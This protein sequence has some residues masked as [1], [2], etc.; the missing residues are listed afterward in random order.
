M[1][2]G[3]HHRGGPGLDQD[4]PEVLGQ[5]LPEPGVQTVVA[6]NQF[7]QQ[8]I[9]IGEPRE[10]LVPTQKLITPGNVSIDHFLCYDASGDPLG[11]P[12]TVQD[13]FHGEVAD[14]RLTFD[15]LERGPEVWRVD[16]VRRA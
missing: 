4:P 9:Q 8:V 2:V 11:V 10:L 16:V 15:Y 14:A 1:V 3:H 12:V 7:G 6:T 13:Q 5:P